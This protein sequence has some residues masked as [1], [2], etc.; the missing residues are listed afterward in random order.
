LT[1]TK[2]HSISFAVIGALIGITVSISTTEQ[3]ALAFK[4]TGTSYQDGYNK[5][6]ADAR[7]DHNFCHG[8]GYDPSCPRGHTATRVVVDPGNKSPA[9]P[10]G[11]PVKSHNAAGEP[12][13]GVPIIIRF[14][15]LSMPL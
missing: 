4:V 15:T 10:K 5:G 7:C 11:Q 13:L 3:N 6:F 2:R 12:A 14:A 1:Y 8:H 9:E